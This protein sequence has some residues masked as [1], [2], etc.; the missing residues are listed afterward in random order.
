MN[1]LI[2]TFGKSLKSRNKFFVFWLQPKKVILLHESSQRETLDQ[3]KIKIQGLEMFFDKGQQLFF[4]EPHPIISFEV[5]TPHL[6]FAAGSSAQD[7][8]KT[9][10]ND[11]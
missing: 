1:N 10:P 9:W 7:C 2:N 3:I 6:L 5:T 4:L 11:S 8:K